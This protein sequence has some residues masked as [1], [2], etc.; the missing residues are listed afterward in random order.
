MRLISGRCNAGTAAVCLLLAGSHA[1][2]P[3]AC[4][5]EATCETCHHAQAGE[6]SASVH[7]ALGCRECHQ[8]QPVYE[9]DDAVLRRYLD[10]ASGSRP[11]FDHGNAFAGKPS[12]TEV[13]ERCGT[14]HA[15]VARMNPYGLRTDQLARYW[16]SNH[17]RRLKEEGD[18]RV[19]VCI[20][21][22]GSHRV[23]AG[24]EPTSSTHPLNVP[25]TC[26]TCHAD[27]GLMRDYDLPVEVVDEYRRSVHGQLLLERGDTGAPTCATC[28]GNHSAMPPGFATV[29]AVCGKCHQAAAANFAQS[30]HS[31]VAFHKGC[32]QCHGGGEDRQFHL[33]ERITNPGGILIQR[34]EHLL[35]TEPEPTAE[36]IAEAIHADPKEIMTRALPTCYECHDELEF[37]EGLQKLFAL[38]DQIAVAER[39]YV[40]TGRR[41]DEVGKGVV[42]VERQRFLFEDAK[43][44]LIELAPLQHTLDNDKV[45]GKV[46]ELEEVCVQVN[47]ELDELQAGLRLRQ[48]ALL[49]VWA[50][51]AA[52]SA[53]LY[54][55]WK[56]LKKRHVKPLG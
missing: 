10:G 15:D 51:A 56:R 46:E 13:P 16:T 23:Q 37:D 5:A 26:A 12:R 45:A 3:R 24:S 14:C 29:G 8:G 42:L 38:L 21:C 22:H 19:A 52:F 53:L 43:T 17:G 44:H 2:A 54:V 39:T 32:V 28:H 47:R 50:F 36:E 4:A 25:A 40:Q 55:K 33:I 18:E 48:R 7:A 41:L 6:L 49:P 1:A 31:T 30:V 11:A 34:Y 9:V 27:A 20:D 35:Q